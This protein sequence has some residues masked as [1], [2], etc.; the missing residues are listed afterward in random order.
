MSARIRDLFRHCKVK[1]NYEKRFV[2]FKTKDDCRLFEGD[3]LD[4]AR[5][6]PTIKNRFY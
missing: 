2:H 6:M 3:Y 4:L 1:N 5:S